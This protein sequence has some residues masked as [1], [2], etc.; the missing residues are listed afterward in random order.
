MM[1]LKEI[2]AQQMQVL[3]CMD[4]GRFAMMEKIS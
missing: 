2:T 3:E 4:L 1:V